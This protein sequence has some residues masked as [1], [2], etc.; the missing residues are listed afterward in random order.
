MVSTAVENLSV[1]AK[2]RQRFLVQVTYDTSRRQLDKLVTAI[3][4]LLADNALVD[5]V[6]A[7]CASITSP[8]AA[9]TSW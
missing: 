1:R 8:K 5:R 9:W 2:R 3:R 4:Q 6:F 7:M